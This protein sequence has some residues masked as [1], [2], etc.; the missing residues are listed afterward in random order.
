VRYNGVAFWFSYARDTDPKGGSG[1][2][3]RAPFRLFQAA[4]AKTVR[5]RRKG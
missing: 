3:P 5:I 2:R 1:V 4:R